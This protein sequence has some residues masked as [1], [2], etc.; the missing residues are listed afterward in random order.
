MQLHLVSSFHANLAYLGSSSRRGGPGNSERRKMDEERSSAC[1]IKVANLACCPNYW[2]S[3][4]FRA[5]SEWFW[6]PECSL[7]PT[8]N[9]PFCW[10]KNLLWCWAEPEI[11]SLMTMFIYFLQGLFP[12]VKCTSHMPW[13]MTSQTSINIF[14]SL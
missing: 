1:R 5:L 10:G 13:C 4:G 9:A 7:T 11:R 14:L 2:N 8:T 12:L 3:D 6:R